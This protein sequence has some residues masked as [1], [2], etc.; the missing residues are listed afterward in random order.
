M[1]SILIIKVN[2]EV[3][4]KGRRRGYLVFKCKTKSR[5]INVEFQIVTSV[6]ID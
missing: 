6:G 3:I 4:L 1:V 2:I 5:Q